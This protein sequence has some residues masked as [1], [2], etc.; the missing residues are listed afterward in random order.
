M[1]DYPE[2]KH[3]EFIGLRLPDELSRKIREQAR[4]EGMSISDLLRKIAQEYV[5]EMEKMRE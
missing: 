4:L 5:E 3:G 2:K 1:R